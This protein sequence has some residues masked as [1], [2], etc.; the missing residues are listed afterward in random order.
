MAYRPCFSPALWLSLEGFSRA[1]EHVHHGICWAVIDEWMF[2]VKK[3]TPS[4]FSLV[5]QY[6]SLDQVTPVAKH[7]PGINRL[8]TWIN[9]HQYPLLSCTGAMLRKMKPFTA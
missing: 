4:R 1:F 6:Y 3:F 8:C 5:A 9:R 2:A 7:L